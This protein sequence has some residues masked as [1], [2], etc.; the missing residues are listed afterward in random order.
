M[1]GGGGGAFSRNRSSSRTGPWAGVQPYLTDV[2]GEAQGLYRSG[3]PAY[4]PGATYTPFNP[5]QQQAMAAQQQRAIQGSPQ[6]QQLGQFISGQLQQPGV[7]TAAAQQAA[8][9]AAAGTGAGQ[10]ALLNQTG[11]MGLGQAQQFAQGGNQAPFMQALGAQTQFGGPGQHAAFLGQGPQWAQQALQQAGQ[12][13]TLGDTIG[14]VQDAVGTGIDPTAQQTLTQTAQG[15]SLQGN[16]FLDDQFQ[17]ATQ[18]I[19]ERFQE[20]TQPGIAA[21]FGAAGRTGGGLQGQALGAAQGELARELGG[22]ATDIY[23]QN[24][25]LERQ[26]QLQAADQLGQLGLGAGQLGLGAAGLGADIY[27]GQQQRALGAAQFGLGQDL[28][29]GQSAID[30]YLSERGLGQ[31]AAQSGAQLGLGQQRLG[32]DL[33]SDAQQRALAAG[34]GLLEGGL[35]GGQQLGD[36][37]SRVGAQQLGAAG[38]VPALSDLQYGNIDR[39]RGVGE[40]VYGLQQQIL[41]DDIN[42][43]NYYQ[44]GPQNLLANYAAILQGLSPQAGRSRASGFSISGYGQGGAGLG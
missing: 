29:R 42:R 18:Q 22:V 9:Q 38:M 31:Q 25:Q 7:D 32:A 15:Q 20:I 10:Q 44:Q 43:F 26:R 37:Y 23:G 12:G 19:G 34:Q 40:D 35:Q 8:Q 17:R 27:G 28:E 16:P 3:V 41:A 36:L 4:Y 21:Q 2:Y 1:S 33:Y 6:E 24:Y 14:Q 30:A 13:G 39:L 11:G 5:I